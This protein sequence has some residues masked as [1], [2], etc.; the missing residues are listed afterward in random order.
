MNEDRLKELEALANAATEGPWAVLEQGEKLDESFCE[1]WNRV[2]PNEEKS[3]ARI[4]Q[5]WMRYQC[6]NGDASEFTK[7][8]IQANVAFIAASCTAIPELIAEVRRLREALE[9]YADPMTYIHGNDRAPCRALRDRG[10]RALE[11]LEEKK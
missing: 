11:A 5:S 6:E 4:G 3:V 2:G 8:E 9:F 7:E 10:Q 1:I